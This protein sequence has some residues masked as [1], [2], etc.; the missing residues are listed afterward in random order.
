MKLLLLLA[1]TALATWHKPLPGH[2]SLLSRDTDFNGDCTINTTCSECFGPGNI[3]C[4]NAG[5]FNPNKGEQCCKDGFYCVAKD[6]SC[7][8]DIPGPGT[9]GPDGVVPWLAASPSSTAGTDTITCTPQQTNEECC[10][11]N[12]RYPSLKW[13]SG[14]YPNQVCYNPKHQICCSEGTVCYGEGCCDLVSASAITPD[15][16]LAAASPGG[17]NGSAA[18]STWGSGASQTAGATDSAII[19]TATVPS[20]PSQ[21]TNAAL[22]TQI[23]GVLMGVGVVMAG[24]GL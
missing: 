8:G 14:S 9:P 4:D 6:N 17:N 2:A 16:T 24:L 7:C 12:G 19:A 13:C 11:Q 21:S 3:V 1:S 18:S 10:S 22:A 20:I 23:N 15:P 5:C